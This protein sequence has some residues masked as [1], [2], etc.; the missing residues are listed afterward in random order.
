MKVSD[1]QNTVTLRL[2]FVE[3]CDCD[4]CRFRN[5]ATGC[6]APSGGHGLCVSR[7]DGKEGSFKE[8]A[9]CE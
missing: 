6:H 5:G 7:V 3:G 1:D 8:V 9:T 2:V 4:A